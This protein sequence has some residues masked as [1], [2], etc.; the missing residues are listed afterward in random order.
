[1][2]SLDFSILENILCHAQ[3]L[4][5]KAYL[6]T[7]AQ[8]ATLACCE[9][10]CLPSKLLKVKEA[11]CLTTANFN[12]FSYILNALHSLHTTVF[13]ILDVTPS[14]ITP[15]IGLSYSEELD[16]AAKLLVEGLLKLYSPFEYE[17][18]NP[19]D[20][21]HVDQ[22]NQ[23]AST[24]FFPSVTLPTS[25]T[26]LTLS[27]FITLTNHSTYT[28]VLTAS[29]ICQS[30]YL[31]QQTELQC[32]YTKLFPFNEISYANQHHVTKTCTTTCTDTHSRSETD[33]CNK[34]TTSGCT[35]TLAHNVSDVT[36]SNLTPND[37][38]TIIKNN[39]ISNN[40]SR[41]NNCSETLSDSTS[42]QKSCSKSSTQSD[43][44]T[45]LTI[46]TTNYSTRNLQVAQLLE[47]IPIYLTRYEATRFD[48][49]FNFNTYFIS[50][51]TT[52]C[53]FAASSYMGLLAT[54][55]PNIYPQALNIWSPDHVCFHPLLET[56]TS[57]TMPSFCDPSLDSECCLGM[58]ITSKELNAFLTPLIL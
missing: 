45:D 13:Y 48:S 21:F 52:D 54:L 57:L 34:S 38:L 9:P 6:T 2:Y 25:C 28:L 31:C 40:D 51:N 46:H 14:S 16:T 4:L 47:Q 3:Q 23:I 30:C 17:W 20:V 29:P 18:I 19:T 22:I 11:T 41:T 33:T 8:C 5:Y 32:L 36:S 27:P 7:L 35:T 37:A 39:N 44:C 53:L 26:N 24:T 15:Y 12:T 49:I 55:S 1:M 42:K 10:P 56:L 43:T 58:P 50:P